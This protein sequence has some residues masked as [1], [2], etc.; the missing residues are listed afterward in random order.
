MKG[1]QPRIVVVGSM[2]TDLVFRVKSWPGAG[3]TVLGTDFGMFLGGKGFNQAVAC[4]RLGADVAMAGR[5]GEDQFGERFLAMLDD[6][7]IGTE[8]VRR[9][10]AGTAVACPIVDEAGENSIIA[11]P[12]ANM[13]VTRRD[14]DRVAPKIAEADVLML[15]FEIPLKV[16]AYAA[17]IAAEHKTTVLLDPAP[18]SHGARE[19][20]TQVDY[21]VPN[22]V[23]A[24]M[25]TYRMLQADWG[26]VLSAYARRGVVVSMGEEGAM[27]Y[28]K[29]GL[30]DFPAPKVHVVDTTG[31]G[32]AFRAGLAVRLAEG[33]TLDEA[34]VFANACG[35]LACTVMGAEPSMPERTAVEKLLAAGS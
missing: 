27:V 20:G 2:V 5:V 22:E 12:R 26:R 33:A 19:L 25:L 10:K 24:H 18:A 8:Y 15:Q 28:D 3:E 30:R 34:V 4:R 9:D 17:G 11:V 32:D 21:I 29:A 35:S 31:A 7:G 16:S 1:K 14:V 23:E 6:S 13:K